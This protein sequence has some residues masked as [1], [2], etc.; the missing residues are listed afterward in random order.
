MSKYGSSSFSVLLVDGFDMLAAKLQAFSHGEES[1][2]EQTNGLGDGHVQHS[3]VNMTQATLSQ[4]GA[5]FDDAA[6][7]IHEAFKASSHVNRILCFAFMGN[8]V[9]QAFT[10]A[11]GAFRQR[12]EVLVAAPGLTKANATYVI[13]G[14]TEDGVILQA[15]GAKTADWNTEVSDPV[16]YTL[17]TSQRVIPIT[18]NSQATPTVVTCPVAHGRATGDIILISGESGSSPTINGER[19]ITVLSPTTFSVP[20][21]TSAGSGGTGGSF[22]RANSVDGGAGVQQVSDLFGFSGY[23]GTVRD[24]ADNVTYADLVTFAA[25]TAAPAKERVAVAGVVDRYLAFDGNVTGT[26]SIT[27]FAGFSRG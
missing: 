26:G 8:T 18:S 21:D 4:S 13:D 19:T 17:D 24:S 10:A 1:L 5:F 15:H 9:G 6:N 11:V 2:T 3:P 14:V 20:V 27:P 22:V 12:Y 23:V 25:V 7:G 16:D